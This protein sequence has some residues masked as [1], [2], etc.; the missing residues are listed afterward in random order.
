MESSEFPSA[1]AQVEF[2]EGIQGLLSGGGFTATYKCALLHALADLAVQRPGP[3]MAAV[4]IPI[5]EIGERFVDLYW[6]QAREYL[7][8]GRILRQNTGKRAAIFTY[9]HD[10][11]K[12]SLHRLQQTGQWSQL[13][14]QAAALVKRMPLFRLQRVGRSVNE[15]LYKNEEVDGNIVLL[16]GVAFCLA[17]FHRLVTGL[18]RSEW[19]NMVRRLNPDTL[20]DAVELGEFLFGRDRASLAGYGAA[21]TE[22]CSLRCFY[23]GG[24]IVR[25]E[26][27]VD[28]FIPWS[29]YPTDFGH[30]FVLVDATCNGQKSDYLAAEEHLARWLARNREIGSDLSECFEAHGLRHDLGATNAI[31]RWAYER[32]ITSRDSL[33]IKGRRT[34]PASSN[35]RTLMKN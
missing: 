4:P 19:T 17:R 5:R 18:A 15:F 25:G 22:V 26:L 10:V 6:Q 20:G 7:D 2:M 14:N 29:R 31:A 9:I 8:S 16:P 30:N 34:E 21:L 1:A 33:W 11:H 24:A 28:H 13:V 35:L 23:C 3:P 27:H 32:A 12:E